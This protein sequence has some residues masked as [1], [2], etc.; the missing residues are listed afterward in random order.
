M[1]KNM[2]VLVCVIVRVEHTL[3]MCYFYQKQYF[4]LRSVAYPGASL[5]PPYDF[6]KKKS[7]Y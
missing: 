7:E 3:E 6:T 2:R 1:C 5:L 4:L